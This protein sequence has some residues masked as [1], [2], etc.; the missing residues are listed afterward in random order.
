MYYIYITSI[1]NDNG[2]IKNKIKNFSVKIL[3]T[4][5]LFKTSTD[6]TSVH[7]RKKIY[8]YLLI[9]KIQFSRV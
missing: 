2:I 4:T 6:Q 7:V 9:L 3:V 8:L 5:F 1:N